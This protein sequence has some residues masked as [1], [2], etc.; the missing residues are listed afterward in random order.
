MLPRPLLIACLAASAGGARIA[1]A[2]P[3]ADVGATL[4]VTRPADLSWAAGSDATSW[5]AYRGSDPGA[6][7]ARCW[8][9]GL[10][11]PATADADPAAP[12]SY[13]LISASN[14]EGESGLGADGL[15][16]PRTA[17]PRCDSDGDGV[18]D[19]LDDCPTLANAS[20]ADQDEDGE[21]D[22]CDP[23]T[24]DFEADAPGSRPSQTRAVGGMDP[25]F[26][27]RDAGGDRV[28]SYSEAL[29]GAHDELLRL[30]GDAP[31]QDLDAYLDVEDV[32]Q[33]ASIEL[34][35]DGAYAWLAGGGLIV[36]VDGAGRVLLY[37]R[38][39]R[40]VPQIV[41]PSLPPDGRLRIRVRKGADATTRVHVDVRDGA[42]W[43]E[44]H[45]F[46]VADDHRLRGS[47]VVLANYIGGRRGVRRVTVNRVVPP[48]PLTV[49]QDAATSE[50]WKLFQ[51][52]AADRARIPVR[53]AW[54]APEAV[55]L[56]AAV[57]SSVTR[58]PLPGHDFADH[59]ID[60]PAAPEGAF[61]A[62]DVAGVPAG[63]NYDVVLRLERA[64]DGVAIGGGAIESVAVGDTWL[65]A[66]QSNMSGYSG[67]L[68]GAEMPSDDVHLFANSG[69]WRL[70]AEPMDDGTDQVDGVSAE[71]PAH[72]LQLRFAKEMSGALGVPIGI[73]P[74]PLGGTSLY[75]QWQRDASDPA[76]RG[77]LYGSM[78]H[79]ALLQGGEPPRGILWMQGESDALALR[80]TAAY[81]DD[82]ERLIAQYRSDLGSARLHAVVG[83][84]GVFLSSDLVQWTAIQEAQRQAALA[85]PGI[86]LAVTIDQPL[87]DP[88]H[89]STAG[90]R[91]IGTRFAEAALEELHGLPL[92]SR[93]ELVSAR[94]AAGG[95]AIELTYDADVSGGV[96]GAYVVADAAGTP[97]VLLASA[98]G[99][100]V[101][102]LLDR[103]LAAPATVG[104]GFLRDPA[105]A[106]VR[107]ARGRPV[108]CF[109][110][111]VVAP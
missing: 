62:M 79:R 84:L 19:A 53:F 98:S 29:P 67:S 17:D 22:A 104:Y 13:Y 78:L 28:A 1:R 32:P 63:G 14:A 75:A 52:D 101:E 26:L 51:R 55:R 37:P 38:V 71:A 33:V 99:R 61:G 64:S 24:Y 21:G 12:L 111:V 59:A 30:R 90:Y 31:F 96:A 103:P 68:A 74:G 8:Q 48:G 73:V 88:I 66:G 23:Q 10:A 39:W 34:W 72:S 36:Q 44:A 49:L 93:A 100:V 107:D 91:A 80:G 85:D 7:D 57:M 105:A 35:S 45:A 47:A 11:T 102:L 65:A 15:G 92:D 70:A 9:P 56:R 106:W 40:N 77:T 4:R 69:A 86:S 2:A 43:T 27:V 87:A 110:D 82:L 50:S 97:A 94:V 54:R 16:R 6:G 3:P 76:S 108:A 42:G 46:E 83:Q 81:R 109:A 5:N 58:L 89:F 18:P 95:S 20:Q 60:L 25:T 41:G